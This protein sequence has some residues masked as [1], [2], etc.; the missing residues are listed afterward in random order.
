MDQKPG[1]CRR[2]SR[3]FD[4]L[5]SQAVDEDFGTR[6]A[7]VRYFGWIR[8]LLSPWLVWPETG[9]VVILAETFVNLFEAFRFSAHCATCSSMILVPSLAAN[10]L[11][12][13]ISTSLGRSFVS[14]VYRPFSVSR[15]LRQIDM[16]TV[17][18]SK[19]LAQLRSLMK[20]NK[21]DI[22]SMCRENHLTWQAI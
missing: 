7:Q 2:N 22:Y 19:R 11:K 13:L 18:T 15:L 17:D 5:L 4:T 21:V 6:L 16:E 3:A 8:A 12:P 1:M 14:I 20:E 10:F 9:A